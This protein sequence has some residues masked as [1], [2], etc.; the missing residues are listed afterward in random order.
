MGE[1]CSVIFLQLPLYDCNVEDARFVEEKDVKTLQNFVENV[2]NN[3]IGV[4]KV[5][6]IGKDSDNCGENE[7]DFE[8][9]MNAALKGLKIG[10]TVSFSLP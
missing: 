1:I 3:V 6:E 9:T 8:K 7:D 2:R 10:E 5:V 4:G